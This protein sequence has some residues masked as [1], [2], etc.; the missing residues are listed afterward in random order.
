MSAHELTAAAEKLRKVAAKVTEADDN[1]T[2][3]AVHFGHFEA[4]NGL[5]DADAAWIALMH[6]G[7][8]EPLA[9]WLEQ[10]AEAHDGL[11]RTG[12]GDAAELI[13][14][15]AIAVAQAINGSGS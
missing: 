10:A 13:Y 7:L 1:P 9:A 8:A 11:V 4:S 6:P 2:S 15:P 12:C 14:Q 3:W 5:C